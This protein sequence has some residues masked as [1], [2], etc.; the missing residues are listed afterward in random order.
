MPETGA[1]LLWSWFCLLILHQEL[2][3][4]KCRNQEQSCSVPWFRICHLCRS[5]Q[6]DHPSPASLLCP[7]ATGCTAP[8]FGALQ[9]RRV[10][11]KGLQYIQW[12]VFSSMPSS[13]T[14]LEV[15]LSW[16]QS[17]AVAGGRSF[18]TSISSVSIV[19]LPSGGWTLFYDQD[20]AR[21]PHLLVIITITDI[22]INISIVAILCTVTVTYP[23][24]DNHPIQSIHY[25]PFKT[26]YRNI[27]FFF[28]PVCRLVPWQ[29]ACYR[30]GCSL[31]LSGLCWPGESCGGTHQ[32]NDWQVWRSA[33]FTLHNHVGQWGRLLASDVHQLLINAPRQA[34]RA[35][36][37]TGRPGWF[38]FTRYTGNKQMQQVS[39]ARCQVN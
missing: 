7:E 38:R 4:E 3:L 30:V 27:Q 26:C 21:C 37:N 36:D 35:P 32:W 23:Y 39:S 14:Q 12:P 31:Y 25:R 24:Q 28:S 1:S 18:F 34:I 9:L 20:I 8:E 10:W 13:W 22:V 11:A 29:P 17:S 5:H 19:E 16:G 15:E 6:P 2:L 33:Q